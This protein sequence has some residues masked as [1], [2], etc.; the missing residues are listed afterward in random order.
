[1]K[2]PFLHGCRGVWFHEIYPN[3]FASKI[4][5]VRKYSQE[6][7]SAMCVESSSEL[8]WDCVNWVW[9]T[10]KTSK[11][12]ERLLRCTQGMCFQCLLSDH[13]VGLN[14]GKAQECAWKH[15]VVPSFTHS[16]AERRC[17]Q[18]DM[19]GTAKIRLEQQNK[20]GQNL[21][22]TQIV[23]VCFVECPLGVDDAICQSYQPSGVSSPHSRLARHRRFLHGV[24]LRVSLKFDTQSRRNVI[25]AHPPQKSHLFVSLIGQPF[26]FWKW[27]TLTFR[28][29]RGDIHEVF[30]RYFQGVAGCFGCICFHGVRRDVLVAVGWNLRVETSQ[31]GNVWK[32]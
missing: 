20:F 25:L 1:M 30:P 24:V 10:K 2:H 21:K 31:T 27:L 11:N 22:S 4:F 26:C 6:R 23:L 8:Y 17:A 29:L 18:H 5:I 19:L 12:N 3:T 7:M 13:S 9:G 32:V 14:D 16:W 28:K 15:C